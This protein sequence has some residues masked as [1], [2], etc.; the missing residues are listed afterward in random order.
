MFILLIFVSIEFYVK[1]GL[2]PTIEMLFSIVEY[3]YY[4]KHIYNNFKVDH[5]GLEL[6][7]AVWRCAEVTTIREFKRRIWQLKDLDPKAR[8]YPDDINSA[9]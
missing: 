3:R 8:E 2:I 6:K 5:K 1:Q 7:D 9:Q 4:V